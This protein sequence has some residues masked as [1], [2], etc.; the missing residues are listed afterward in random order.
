[1]PPLITFSDN[2]PY[3]VWKTDDNAVGQPSSIYMRRVEE[4]GVTFVDGSETFLLMSA[5]EPSDS[6]IVEGP[7]ILYEEP[8]YYMFFSGNGYTSPNYH[9]TVS[10]SIAATGK[11]LGLANT[12]LSEIHCQV[13]VKH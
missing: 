1:M 13:S 6:N 11:N 5:T 10:R 4:D 12:R 9:V 3:L 8:Y 7:W 2:L